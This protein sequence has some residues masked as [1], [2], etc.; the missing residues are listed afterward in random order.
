MDI[1][2]P[3]WLEPL[4]NFYGIPWPDID[5][6]AFLEL[7]QRLRNFG[8]DLTA[9]GDSIESALHVLESGN[10]SHTLQAI[11]TH[12][13]TIR[14][15]FLEPV[16]GICNELAGDPCTVAYV[17]ITALKESLLVVLFAEMGDDLLDVASAVLTLGLDS[18]AAAAEAVA[19]KEVVSE[20][21]SAAEGDLAYKIQSSADRYLDDLVT[22][23]LT[24]FISRVASSLEGAV[25]SYV[26]QLLLD[27]SKANDA[28]G[29]VLH[30]SP[31]AVDQCVDSIAESSSHLT[32]AGTKL[33]AAIEEIFS[34][35]APRPASHSLSS[36]LRLAAAS[37]VETVERD[38]VAGLGELIDHIVSHFTALLQA[39]ERAV[40]DLDH[41]ARAV[42][43]REHARLVPEVILLSAAGLGV[44]S[45][46][47]VVRVGATVNG[48]EAGQVQVE[49]VTAVNDARTVAVPANQAPLVTEEMAKSGSAPTELGLRA[50]DPVPAFAPAG[51][52]SAGVQS[53]D[54]DK[55]AATPH[56]AA[57]QGGTAPSLGVRHSHDNARP[58]RDAGPAR[59]PTDEPR[60]DVKRPDG[61]RPVA[62]D[63]STPPEHAVEGLHTTKTP[64]SPRIDGSPVGSE[65]EE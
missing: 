21:L 59:V 57:A 3:T 47:D 64:P 45:A 37:A 27:A 56:V 40:V 61:P 25:D 31:L 4:L 38:L 15:D 52:S 48:E 19:V 14:S 18:A 1:E 39:Y 22:S 12:F 49:A 63:T 32:S 6:N 23:L 34:H 20:M 60:L 51:A 41:Q 7:P 33:H 11:S 8:E 17:A 65:T 55:N 26:P 9:V 43:A 46:V 36:A 53:L 54:P 28:L 62:R 50:S 30:L 16:K 42:A 24:P 35:P 29:E 10:P 58:V 5:E 2:I 13:A 44:A